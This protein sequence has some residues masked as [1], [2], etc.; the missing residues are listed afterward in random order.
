MSSRKRFL[1]LNYFTRLLSF[2]FLVLGMINNNLLVI[3]A[4]FI[5]IIFELSIFMGTFGPVKSLPVESPLE[6]AVSLAVIYIFVGIIIKEPSKIL[7][8]IILF[9][10]I[11]VYTLWYIRSKVRDE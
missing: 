9:F 10:T 11:I 2:T 6:N 1:L 4:F 8:Y 3:L 7:M 5:F